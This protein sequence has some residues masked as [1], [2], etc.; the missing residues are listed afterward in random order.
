MAEDVVSADV[1]LS[2]RD[3]GHLADAQMVALPTMTGHRITLRV[4]PET[5]QIRHTPTAC[6]R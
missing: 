6:C 5:C 2:C 3:L 1:V 4:D